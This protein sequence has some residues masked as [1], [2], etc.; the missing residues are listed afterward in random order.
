MS[1]LSAPL[2]TPRAASI[3]RRAAGAL[4]IHGP[5]AR[6][7]ICCVTFAGCKS[8]LDKGVDINDVYGPAGRHALN[9]AEQA[10]KE[11]NGEAAVGV[12]ELNAARKLY[13]DQK[14]AEARKAFHK[15]VQKYGKKSE[16]V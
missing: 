2:I 10:K 8:P 7:A 15:I 1:P 5:W 16:P 9:V 6:L 13:E 12:D 3:L 14:Y 11:A 4:R